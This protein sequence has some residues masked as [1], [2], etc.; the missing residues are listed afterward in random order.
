MI[1][2]VHRK[3]IR[4]LNGWDEQADEGEEGPALPG[5]NQTLLL[6]MVTMVT[7]NITNMAIMVICDYL[8]VVIMVIIDSSFDDCMVDCNIGES[9]IQNMLD[10][11]SVVD[12]GYC[13]CDCD[14]YC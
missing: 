11:I 14:C 4:L 13:D 1:R 7:T 2:N 10:V 3:H 8:F 6:T 12:P 5:D 9:D